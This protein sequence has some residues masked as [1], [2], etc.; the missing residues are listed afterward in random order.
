M[1][2]APKPNTEKITSEH[3]DENLSDLGH[4][5]FTVDVLSSSNST[6]DQ[7]SD[8]MARK[9]RKPAAAKPAAAKTR[10][11]PVKKKK[12]RAIA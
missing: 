5:T 1:S 2:P 12:R 3:D 10:A 9:E 11:T 6:S 4:S 8:T 7:K